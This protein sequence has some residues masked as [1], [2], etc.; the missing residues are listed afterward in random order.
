MDRGLYIA[1]SGMLSEMARQDILA[2]DLAN[3][4][5]P[6]YKADRAEQRSFQDVLLQNTQTGATV[7]P[8]GPGS[9]IA[10]Q[11]TDFT[12]APAKDT[13]Q[14]LDF[15][16]EGDGFFSVRT[17]QGQRFTRNGSFQ[18]G[19]NGLLVD[20]LGNQV[21]DQRG[22]PI[23]VAAD[24][25]V[26]PAKLGIYTVN[27][28]RKA[29]DSNFTGTAAGK[30]TGSVRSG[31]LEGSGVDP[32]HAMIDMMTSLRAYESGQKAIQTIDSTLEQAAT[33]VGSI[34]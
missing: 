27:G 3:S 5:T 13:G 18:T 15:A 30:A 12:P 2:N 7:G 26:D 20:Q 16:I 9:Y 19:P 4:S 8:I 6:G 17:P 10:R 33:K 25:T 22:Q 23:K 34:S 1:A 11:N 28:A 24:G 14:D 29:G 21:M 32:A 31:A